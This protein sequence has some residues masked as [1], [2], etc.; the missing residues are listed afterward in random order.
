MNVTL[1]GNTP[2]TNQNFLNYANSGAWDG[3]FFHRNALDATTHAKTHFIIQAGGFRVVNDQFDFVP[4]F[5]TIQN[6]PVNHNERGTIAMAKLGGDPNS[7]SNQ[8]FFNLGNNIANLDQQNGG[9][10]AFGELDQ[11][12]LAVMDAIDNN[13]A[14]GD[15]TSNSQLLTAVNTTPA[16]L[17]DPQNRFVGALNEMPLV[18]IQTINNTGKI[19]PN[20]DA[21]II[22]RVSLQMN[23]LPSSTTGVSPAT[24]RPAAAAAPTVAQ[25]PAAAP[26]AAANNSLF[27]T[28]DDPSVWA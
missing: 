27:A 15:V 12:S 5:G 25:A 21:V 4:D 14:V 17:N 6:E 13:F 19:D 16:A 3:T 26:A 8:F 18:N 20:R 7:A 23:I 10:T 24:A 22:F 2:I 11:A 28:K 9:F 1:D